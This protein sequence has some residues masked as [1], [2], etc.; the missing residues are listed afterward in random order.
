[1]L[2]IQ[3]TILTVKFDNDNTDARGVV[4]VN[5]FSIAKTSP[6]AGMCPAFK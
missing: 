2:I 4:V 1:M 5:N 3:P 6:Y